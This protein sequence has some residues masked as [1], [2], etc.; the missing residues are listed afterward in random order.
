MKFLNVD[1]RVPTVPTMDTATGDS[2]NTQNTPVS[3]VAVPTVPTVPSKNIIHIENSVCVD[4]DTHIQHTHTHST[5]KGGVLV[6]ESGNGN[7]LGDLQ[8]VEAVFGVGTSGNTTGNKPGTNHRNTAQRSPLPITMWGN[9]LSQSE[10][11]ALQH[12]LSPSYQTRR[13]KDSGGYFVRCP[14]WQLVMDPDWIPANSQ[15]AMDRLAAWLDCG[16]DGLGVDIPE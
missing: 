1:L 14:Y 12:E 3:G 11:I 8:V 2:G 6:S 4:G 7:T 15:E 9:N 10:A 5:S 16:C 13:G